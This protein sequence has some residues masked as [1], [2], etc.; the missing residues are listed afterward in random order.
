M[1]MLVNIVY[2]EDLIIKKIDVYINE[3]NMLR[4]KLVINCKYKLAT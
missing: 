3:T 2:N 4:N 1:N